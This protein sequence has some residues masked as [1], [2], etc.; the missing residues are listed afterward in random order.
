MIRELKLAAA[1]ADLSGL[2]A[3]GR[4]GGTSFGAPRGTVKRDELCD[5]WPVK[6][7]IVELPVETVASLH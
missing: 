4:R 1:C 6:R 7:A 5:S 3:R 2:S